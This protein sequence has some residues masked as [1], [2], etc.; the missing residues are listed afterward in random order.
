MIITGYFEGGLQELWAGIHDIDLEIDITELI[1]E[2]EEVF[3]TK[4]G[5]KENN[6]PCD[7]FCQIFVNISTYN[8]GS[9][10]LC[11]ILNKFLL[12]LIPLC[13]TWIVLSAGINCI[14]VL[15]VNWNNI[16]TKSRVLC[17]LR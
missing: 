7:N 17:E 2:S 5:T 1:K 3:Q 16:I 9:S 8:T 4:L 13:Q 10:E 12:E 11:A 6:L 14:S 15:Y